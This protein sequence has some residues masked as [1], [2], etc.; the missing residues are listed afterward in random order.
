KDRHRGEKQQEKGKLEERIAHNAALLRY[1]LNKVR[2]T[3]EDP[4]DTDEEIFA[5]LKSTLLRWNA[6]EAPVIGFTPV[7]VGMVAT[8]KEKSNPEDLDKCEK[9]VLEKVS[10]PG[11]LLDRKRN[12][13]SKLEKEII[14]V[15]ERYREQYQS[16]PTDV[17]ASIESIPDFRRMYEKLVVDDIPRHEERLRKHRNEDT[18]NG[19]LVFQNQL[20]TYER[21]IEQKIEHINGHL[22]DISY[23]TDSYIAI[24]Q[25][26]VPESDIREFKSDLK[27]CLTG[28]YGETDHYNETKFLQVKKILDRFKGEREEDRRWTERVTDVRQWYTFGASERYQ[29]D[30]TDKEYYSDSSGKSVG[31]K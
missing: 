19:I 8:E 14:L 10:S 3:T 1:N 31:Q 16:E 17:D 2:D 21:E 5:D 12:A 22:V 27:A 24:V 18:I 23:N 28:I 4:I 25:E 13:Q 15:M 30:H 29:E 6:I 9:E 20:A 26:P 7:T 11:G